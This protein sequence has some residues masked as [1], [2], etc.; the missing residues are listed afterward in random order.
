M[1]ECRSPRRTVVGLQAST[2]SARVPGPAP[3]LVYLVSLILMSL[4]N[5]LGWESGSFPTSHPSSYP[6][7]FIYAQENVDAEFIAVSMWTKC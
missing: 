4:Q 6:F 1:Q 7:T 2:P 3:G 5:F